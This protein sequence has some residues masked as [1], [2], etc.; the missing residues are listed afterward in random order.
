MA[1]GAP[2]IRMGSALC[3]GDNETAR[4]DGAGPQQHMPMRP[5]AGIGEGRR[6]HDHLGS[7][8]AQLAIEMRKAQIIA[9]AEPQLPAG[10]I[11]QHHAVAGGEIV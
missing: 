10:G 4:L 2:A 1:I 3:C 9:D 11:G 5:P 8:Q 7:G 6:H